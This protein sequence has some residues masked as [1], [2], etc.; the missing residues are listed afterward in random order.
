MAN[1]TEISG[2]FRAQVRVAG[3]PSR[4]RTFDTREEAV[5]WGKEYEAEVRAGLPVKPMTTK[6]PEYGVWAN[7]RTRCSNPNTPTY[8]CYGGRG[9]TVCARWSRFENFLADMGLRPSPRHSID[10]IDNDGPYSPENCRW[11]TPK[12]QAW[13]TRRNIRVVHAGRE[14]TFKELALKY[15]VPMA[16]L[17]A[18]HGRG[19]SGAELVRRPR[20]RLVLF[21]QARTAA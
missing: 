6:L 8:N 18:R 2:R 16:T 4:A 20:K 1:V 11:A 13:N 21:R 3:A 19:V 12:M 7:M 9:I 17:R 5:A 10:R 15:K 14:W